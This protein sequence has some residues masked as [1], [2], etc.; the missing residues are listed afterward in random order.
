MARD[1]V[2]IQEAAAVVYRGQRVL[3]VQRPSHGRWAG[4]W[5]FPH[6]ALEPGEVHEAAAARMV[7]QLTG[8]QV[9]IGPEFFSLRH[10]VT[11]HR[12]TLVCFEGQYLAGRFQSAFYR[13]GRWVRPAEL[14]AFPISAPHRRAALRLVQPDRQ[15]NLF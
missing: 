8:M 14:S 11:H 5:E 3:L 4:L 6:A 1:P 2:A 15:L 9:E 13:R 7:P 12:I 10:S